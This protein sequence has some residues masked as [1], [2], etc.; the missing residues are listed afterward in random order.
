[1]SL[2]LPI[3][4]ALEHLINRALKLDEETRAR[5]DDVNG[6]V[7]QLNIT[8]PIPA[9]VTF[10]ITD[11]HVYVSGHYDGDVDTTIRGSLSSLQSLMRNNDAIHRGEASIE[12]DIAT[13]NT[14]KGMASSLDIDWEEQISPLVGDTIAHQ[15]GVASRK[16][17]SWFERTSHSMKANTR[18]YLEEE[19]EFVA[20]ANMLRHFADSVDD[21]Q[22]SVDRLEARLKQL[23][24]SDADKATHP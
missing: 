24:K 10:S 4:V 3:T 17:A 6:K 2:P 7:V 9:L 5:L 14:L 18:E 21:I 22:S 15:L 20:P 13:G 23:E 1:M 12:G 8:S 16:F 11:R 19:V